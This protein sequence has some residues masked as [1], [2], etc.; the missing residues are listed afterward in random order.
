MRIAEEQRRDLPDGVP[1]VWVASEDGICLYLDEN[2][3]ADL[4]DA[5]RRVASAD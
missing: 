3:P 5:C 4:A 2:V 1:A